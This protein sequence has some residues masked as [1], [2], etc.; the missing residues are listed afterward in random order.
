[1]IAGLDMILAQCPCSGGEGGSSLS[2]VEQWLVVATAVGACLLTILIRKSKGVSIMGK[3]GK[4]AIVIVLAIAVVTVIVM[5]NRGT[6]SKPAQQ[7][8]ETSGLPRMVDLGST[9]CIPCKMMTPVLDDLGKEYAGRMHVEFIDVNANPDA[10]KPYG[11]KLI[12]TQVFYDANGKELWRHEGFI[13]K[14]DILAKWQELGVSF[15]AV[16]LANSRPASA[17]K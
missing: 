8:A 11:I 3:A 13:S 12:P 9:T 10:A 16:S 17:P 14:Q 6:P 7:S 1:M 15:T 5:K 2:N 4:I